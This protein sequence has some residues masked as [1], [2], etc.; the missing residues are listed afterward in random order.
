MTM[1][2]VEMLAPAAA[3]VLWSLIV[4][5]W[6][7]ITRFSAF[8]KQGVSISS[9]EARGR[10]GADLNGVLPDKTMW[11]SHNYDHLMENPTIFYPAVIILALVGATQLDV[12]LA[13]AYVILRIVHSLWQGL[14]NTLPVRATLFSLTNVC[15]LILAIRAVMATMGAV[16]G[17]AS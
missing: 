4:L 13:W 16:L 1:V 10:R 6:A 7:V 2:A 14:V 11:K 9:E 15:L 5:F 12:G 3:L 8:A 17:G